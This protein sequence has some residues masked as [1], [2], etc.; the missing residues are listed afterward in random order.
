MTPP[1]GP[2][3]AELAELYDRYSRVLLFRCWSILGS[4]EL[5]QDA[6]Q[7]T[8]ARVIQ[9]WE[10]FRQE[11]SPLTWMYR[12]SSNYCLN[13]LRNRKRA[14]RN[15]LT[16]QTDLGPAIEGSG[17]QDRWECA[18]IVRALLDDADDETRRVMVALY[19]DDMSLREAAVAVGLSV[20]TVRKRAQRFFKRARRLVGA[21]PAPVAVALILL[22]CLGGWP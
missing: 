19:F 7:E 9:H 18:H 1:P 21:L 3:D 22:S 6:L 14:D 20:P 16:W 5:A 10:T 8:F 13:Q 4:E 11:A 17:G 15:S 2:T 12:I